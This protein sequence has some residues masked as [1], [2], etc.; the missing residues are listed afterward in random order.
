MSRPPHRSVFPLYEAIEMAI[1]EQLDEGSWESFLNAPIAVLVLSKND[2][3]ACVDWTEELNEWFESGETSTE[4]RFGKIM[5]DDPGMARFKI[6]QPWISR[7]DI[8]PFN[9]IFVNGERVKE[10]A[11]GKLPRLQNQL[12]RLM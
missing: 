12:E 10:W 5:L 11:G 2:C 8:L 4:L 6:A 1:I 3:Q 7:V 9:A